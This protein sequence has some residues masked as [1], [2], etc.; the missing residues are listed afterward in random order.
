MHYPRAGR[1]Q[2]HTGKQHHGFLRVA[3]P[4]VVYPPDTAGESSQ[5]GL[6]LNDEVI[7]RVAEDF[8]AVHIRR[9]N[10][11]SIDTATLTE[12]ALFHAIDHVEKKR[13]AEDVVVFLQ[14]ISPLREA[15]D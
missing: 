9:S 10:E 11:L 5:R 2:G 15:E 8:D 3:T 13:P 7:L 4:H 14:A 12:A 1:F 6:T